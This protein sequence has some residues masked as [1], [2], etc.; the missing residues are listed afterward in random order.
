MKKF[1]IIL[2][3][4]LLWA[5]PSV[6]PQEMH[7][8]YFPIVATSCQYQGYPGRG[9]S[10]NF[11][12]EFVTQNTLE[13][14]GLAWE[15]THGLREY[16]PDR[17]DCIETIPMIW[18]ASEGYWTRWLNFVAEDYDGPILLYNEWRW[19][20][21][22]QAPLEDMVEI[23]G[24]LVERHSPEQ[25][26]YGNFA[27]TQFF[28]EDMADFD[29]LYYAIIDAGYPFAPQAVGIHDYT[30][31]DATIQVEG[32]LAHLEQLGIEADLWVTEYGCITVEKAAEYSRYYEQHPKVK[33]WA[34][35]DVCAPP[36]LFQTT[37]VED[38]LMCSSLNERG[39]A[40]S[41]IID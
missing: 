33:R 32:T 29:E 31:T 13:E 16:A 35:F 15:Y 14:L 30:C 8:Y 7:T 2:L 38:I 10:T 40:F 23:Y 4:L 41:A 5:A 26:V 22:C 25:I 6:K 20:D 36:E 12:H 18:C 27:H 34:W 37:L 9:A 39:I 19:R 3:F 1:L 11:N 21:Q 24:R 17:F 28:D